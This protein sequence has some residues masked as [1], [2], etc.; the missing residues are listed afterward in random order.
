[1]CIRDRTCAAEKRRRRKKGE[2]EDPPVRVVVNPEVCEG[3]GDCGIESNCLSVIPHETELGRK[4]KIDQSACN[5]DYSCLRGFCPSFVTVTGGQLK[6]DKVDHSTDWPV[7]P[8][9][10]VAP[11]AEQPWNIVVTGVGGTGVLTIAAVIAMA[12]H[13]EGK[14]CATMNQ[15]GLAQKFGAVVSHVL[16]LIHI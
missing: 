2:L 4:R 13:I 11:M 3:C 12:A 6:K 15:T 10:V 14:G 16:S 9:P 5:K 7:L 1:M 8:E